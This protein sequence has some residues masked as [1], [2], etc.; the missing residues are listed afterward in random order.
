MF[1]YAAISDIGPVFSTNDDMILIGDSIIRE[2]EY[3]G[4]LNTDYVIASVCDGVGGL[5]DGYKAAEISLIQMRLLNHIGVN[6]PEIRKCIEGANYNVIKEQEQSLN[7]S[8]LR[9]TLVALYIDKQKSYAINAGDSRL[10]QYRSKNTILLSKDHSIVQNMIDIGEINELQAM[11]HPKRNIITKCIGDEEKVNARIIEFDGNNGDLYIL[12]SDGISD[13]FCID[14]FNELLKSIESYDL[15]DICR[16]IVKESI[17]RGSTD[18]M[19]IC[20]IR[21]EKE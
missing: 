1:S 9:T 21:R 14:E 16:S 10:Y 11:R 2:G 6:K 7:K 8:G 20:L 5:S 15:I 13:C 3:T 12:C 4:I 19:S 18:N 17:S